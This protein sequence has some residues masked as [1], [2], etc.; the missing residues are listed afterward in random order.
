MQ[1]PWLKKKK[2]KIYKKFHDM[3]LRSKQIQDSPSQK[4][5]KPGLVGNCTCK[6]STWEMEAD[7]TPEVSQLKLRR[8]ALSPSQ[9]STFLGL[10]SNSL[11]RCP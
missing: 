4:P 10:T 5:Q 9:G 1:S 8:E 11:L 2:K 3:W 7:H 6:L